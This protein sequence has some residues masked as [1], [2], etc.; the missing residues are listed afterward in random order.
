MKGKRLRK[1]KH[2]LGKEYTRSKSGKKVPSR[3]SYRDNSGS[4]VNVPNP[5]PRKHT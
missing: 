3:K 1:P 4:Y 5:D 2:E